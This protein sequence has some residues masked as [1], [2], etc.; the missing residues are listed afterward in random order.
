M[1]LTIVSKAVLAT[2]LRASLAVA[3]VPQAPI[4][5]AMPNAPLLSPTEQTRVIEKARD[6][7]LQYLSNLP[8]FICIETIRRYQKGKPAQSWKTFD[9]LVLDLSYSGQGE[10]HRLLSING[11][12]TNKKYF[13]GEVGGFVAT[14]N[15]GSQLSKIF[16]PQAEATFQWE[17]WTNLRGRPSHVFAYR[18]D[19]PHSQWFMR[20]DRNKS[21]TFAVSGL[22][23]V[24]DATLQVMRVT[25]FVDSFPADW[26][27]QEARSEIDYGYVELDGRMFLL[28]IH[29]EN[30]LVA[31]NGAARNMVEFSNYRKFGAEATIQLRP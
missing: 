11:K 5:S 18:V 21:G 13:S 14:G 10:N 7:A 30:I 26:L 28:P 6:N 16:S 17:R 15:F 3:A 8:N 4:E 29:A 19:Q 2:V 22:V 27:P 31:R 25:D 23:Y 9:T 12:P 20:A 1:R 24:D